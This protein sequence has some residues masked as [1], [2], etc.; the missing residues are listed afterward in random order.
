[1]IKHFEFRF[2]GK[3]M[4]CPNCGG[5]TFIKESENKLKCKNCGYVY[6]IK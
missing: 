5:D 3:N 4:I 2:R 1:M 6:H